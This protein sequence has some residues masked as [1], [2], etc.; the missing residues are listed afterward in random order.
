MG[1]GI[2]VVGTDTEVG[3]TILCA[4]LVAGLRGQGIDVGYCKPIST[5]GRE[6]GGRLVSPDALLV[7]KINGLDDSH[8]QLNP[9][10]L[11]APLAPLAAARLEQTPVDM[12]AARMGVESCLK[13]HAFGVIEGIGGLLVPL[14]DDH[15]LLDL[16]VDIGLD[17][18]VAGRANLGT[19]N[20]TLLTINALRARG[21]PVRG[22]CFSGP[23]PEQADDPALAQNPGLVEEFSGAPYLGTLPWIDGEPS[24]ERLAQAA[25][26]LDLAAITRA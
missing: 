8:D 18:L 26:A 9:V 19:I 10:C 17:V 5:D 20:H 24:A 22:F 15:T 23:A 11:A 21:V 14:S 16:V 1:Q 13:A 2:M 3:K 25:S 4:A 12:A 7:A 6:I